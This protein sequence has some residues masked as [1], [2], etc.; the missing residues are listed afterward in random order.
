[1]STRIVIR[2]LIC[3]LFALILLPACV[4]LMDEG[5]L[6]CHENSDCPSGQKCLD[7]FSTPICVALDHCYE[8]YECDSNETCVSNHC[9]VTQCTRTNEQ[10]CGDYSCDLDGKCNTQ[11]FSQSGCK[12]GKVCRSNQCVV[13]PAP[14][15]G[16]S[17]DG[18]VA[19]SSGSCCLNGSRTCEQA[20][21]CNHDYN[22]GAGEHCCKSKT[23]SSSTCHLGECPLAGTGE[24]CASNSDCQSGTCLS[25]GCA[26][27]P[28]PDGSAC[29]TSYECTSSRCVAGV[30]APT[31]KPDGAACTM[32]AECAGNACCGSQITGTKSCTTLGTGESCPVLLGDY[33]TEYD[34]PPGYCDGATNFAADGFCSGGC[35]AA[36]CGYNSRGIKNVCVGN[37]PG[38]SPASACRPGCM[39][40][41]DCQAV[42][43]KLHCYEQPSGNSFCEF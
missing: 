43:P 6:V 12:N 39:T 7:D 30:C 35:P 37:T 21:S 13:P 19:C 34:C 3:A 2:S 41:S 31:P 24:F 32:G 14:G 8:S 18:T 20:C 26:P 16:E 28:Q 15:I 4:R 27:V 22:C 11:C 29:T 1:M 9:K 5:N 40:E 10:A 23:G 33:C 38:S 42:H 36:G 17:C 25:I